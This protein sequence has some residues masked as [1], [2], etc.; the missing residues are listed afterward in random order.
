MTSTL[1]KQNRRH[2]LQALVQEI[3][4][5]TDTNRYNTLFIEL[6]ATLRP[7]RHRPAAEG[8]ESLLALLDQDKQLTLALQQMFVYLFNTRDSQSIFTNVGILSSGTFFSALFRQLRHRIL[9][10][11]PEKRSMNYLLERAFYRK[12]DYKWVRE[13]PDERWIRFFQIAAGGLEKADTP[14]RQYL[15][16]TLTILSYR[17]S[18]LGLEEELSQQL[19]S[20]EEVIT[21]F[22][23]QNKKLLAFIHLVRS[24]TTSEAYLQ[25]SAQDVIDQLNACELIINDIRSQT[26]KFGTSLGQSYLLLRTAQQ[27]KRMFILV[28]FLTPGALPEHTLRNS[29]VLFEDV[30]ESVNKRYSISDLYRKN[31]DMLAYQIAEHKSASGE[32]Y[33]TTTRTEYSGFFFSAAAGGVIIAFA[34]LIKAL[35]HKVHMPLFW[36]YFCY[37]FNYAIAFVALFLTGASLATKQPTMTASALASSLDTRKGGVS[38]QGLALTFG[39]VW[40]SQ[41]ASF[42]GNLVVVFP[43]SYLLSVAWEYLTGTPLLHDKGEALQSLRDQNPLTSLAWLYAGITGICLFTSGIMSGYVDNKVI[44]S[45]LGARMKE[46]QGLRRLF[47]GSTLSKVSDFLVRNLGGIVGNVSLGFMLGFAKLI[48]E[49]FGV[50]FDIRHITIST[51][52]FAFGVDGLENH[53]GAYD[54]IWT[55]IGV[56]GIGF[57]N[58]LISFSLAFYVAVRSRGVALSRLPLAGKLIWKYLVKF[59]QDFI[60]PPKGERKESDVFESQH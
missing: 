11:L 29:V 39:K 47:K 18:Y 56:I 30:I 9:P 52:Y 27:L 21:P 4:S 13:I 26:G 7:G 41:F 1:K 60:Y 38:F 6:I 54:W 43:L 36:Q 59:P 3:K 20:Q 28:R 42:A 46:H 12:T 50:P 22:I 25:S 23:E 40:R 58:F 10:P 57:F 2:D 8:L 24:G 19:K 49:F 5:S 32:H 55:T 31:A 53:L 33:I 17:V 14:F 48:G 51:A 37:G 15:V 35:L 16:N 45:S 44:Y 34:A